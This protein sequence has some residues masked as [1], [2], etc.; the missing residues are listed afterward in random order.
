MD[1]SHFNKCMISQ[2]HF[3]F[4]NKTINRKRVLILAYSF[5]AQLM[6]A[7]K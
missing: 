4:N 6:I 5:S 2:F 7:D 3:S 1:K